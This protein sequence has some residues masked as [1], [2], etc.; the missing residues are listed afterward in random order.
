M[1]KEYEMSK[2]I[3]SKKEN[4]K[5]RYV[6]LRVLAGVCD[7]LWV[8][9]AAFCA[10]FMFISN[11]GEIAIVPPVW[12]WLIANAVAVVGFMA[13]KDVSD[14]IKLTAPL[15]DTMIAV[16]VKSNARSMKADDLE[17]VCSEICSNTLSAKSY[18]QAIEKARVF[19]KP[20]IVFGSLYLAGDI[21]PLLLS[22][23]AT[24]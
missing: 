7:V 21:R 14:A 15:F 18:S 12:Y 4:T 24:K 19:G 11:K 16:E 8:A 3:V 13:D 10:Y 23:F 20:I 17:Q 6:L 9:I 2:Q 22:H 1:K 5:A